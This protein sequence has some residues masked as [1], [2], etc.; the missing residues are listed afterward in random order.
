MDLKRPIPGDHNNGGSESLPSVTVT[1]TYVY[2]MLAN[3][4]FNISFESPQ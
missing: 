2:H 1:H 3:I 4:I